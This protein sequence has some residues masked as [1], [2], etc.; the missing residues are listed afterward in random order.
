[1][2]APDIRIGFH[3][4]LICH[5]FWIKVSQICGHCAGERLSIVGFFYFLF[6][7]QNIARTLIPVVYRNAIWYSCRGGFRQQ[8]EVRYNKTWYYHLL[9]LPPSAMPPGSISMTM[10]A[11][12]VGAVHGYSVFDGKLVN[13][14]WLVFKVKDVRAWKIDCCVIY[15]QFFFSTQHLLHIF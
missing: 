12:G 7:C 13:R 10:K 9:M 3:I 5:W 2:L 6:S 11:P 14:G 8:K 15:L 4:Y 1:M